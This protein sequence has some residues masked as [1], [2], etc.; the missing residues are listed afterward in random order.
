MCDMIVCSI[1]F[2][3]YLIC[4]AS[5]QSQCSP[6]FRCDIGILFHSRFSNLFL[7]VRVTYL[8]LLMLFMLLL[9]KNYLFHPLVVPTNDD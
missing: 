8:D 4:R 6:F 3:P 5:L 9:L 7:L 2:P 1:V